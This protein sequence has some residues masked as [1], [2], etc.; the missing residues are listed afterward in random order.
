MRRAAASCPGLTQTRTPRTPT[1]AWAASRTEPAPH[2]RLGAGAAR[3]GG[4]SP[5]RQQGGGTAWCVSGLRSRARVCFEMK[6]RGKAAFS[7]C[8]GTEKR[9]AP[10]GR[11]GREGASAKGLV[12]GWHPPLPCRPLGSSSPTSSQGLRNCAP[13]DAA[14]HRKCVRPGLARTVLVARLSGRSGL[15]PAGEE[16]SF[17]AQVSC[18]S[19][20]SVE[21]RCRRVGEGSGWA[22]GA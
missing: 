11:G 13:G 22:S 9:E 2:A 12:E 1:L 4:A 20:A 16:G 18:S 17:S 6:W 5:A 14:A 10:A 19:G 21:P 8:R 15:R 7:W 3:R